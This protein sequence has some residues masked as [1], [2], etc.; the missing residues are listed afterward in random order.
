MT[1]APSRRFVIESLTAMA[2]TI[3]AYKFHIIPFVACLLICLFP[4]NLPADIPQIRL[5][6]RAHG[7]NGDDARMLSALSHELRKLDGVVV[8]D[9]QPA[10]KVTFA[11][12]RLTDQGATKFERAASTHRHLGL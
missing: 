11:V 4:C 1:V 9:T 10:L 12:M 6:V 3:P 2:S 5:S 8:T 7:E